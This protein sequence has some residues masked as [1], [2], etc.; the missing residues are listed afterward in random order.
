LKSF[1]PAVSDTRENRLSN[2]ELSRLTRLAE[3][4]NLAKTNLLNKENINSA[5]NPKTT[6]QV[7]YGRRHG[8]TIWI[9]DGALL[10]IIILVILLV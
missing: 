2:E 4:N 9:G 8:G 10:L 3:I 7:E 6:K 1:K 5:K